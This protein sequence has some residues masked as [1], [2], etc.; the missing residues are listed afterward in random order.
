MTGRI[1]RWRFQTWFEGWLFKRDSPFHPISA[2]V[3]LRNFIKVLSR[4]VRIS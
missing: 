4:N 1:R 2:S 3:T